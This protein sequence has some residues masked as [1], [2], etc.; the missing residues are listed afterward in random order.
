MGDTQQ[1]LAWTHWALLIGAD[2]AINSTNTPNSSEAP[3][4]RGRSLKGAVADITAVNDYLTF[5][6]PSGIKVT[7]LTFMKS[8]GEESAEERSENTDGLP[9]IDNVRSALQEITDQCPRGG[10]KE[11]YIH[12]SGHGTRVGGNGPLALVLY[13]PRGRGVSYLRSMELARA[14][15]KMVKLGMR[16]TLVLDCCFSASTHRAGNFQ[17]NKIRFIEYDA[18]ADAESDPAV[19]SFIEEDAHA[20]GVRTSTFQPDRLLDPT[21]YTVI[22]ACGPNENAWEI[23]LSDGVRRGALSYF[24]DRTLKTLRKAGT[25]ISFVTLYHH[26]QARFHAK[27]QQQMPRWYGNTETCFFQDIQ[28]SKD[29]GLEFVFGFYD[30]ENEEFVLNAGEA[31]GVH[32]KDEYEAH[33]YHASEDRVT[34]SNEGLVK[35]RVEE[36]RGLTSRVTVIDPSYIHKLKKSPTWKAKPTISFN[37]RKVPVHLLPSLSDPDRLQLIQSLEGNG[38]LQISSEGNLSESSAFMVGVDSSNAYDIR[39]GG[40]RAILNLPMIT[41]DSGD[42]L[43]LLGTVLTHLT[44]FKFFEGMENREP[45]REFESTFSLDFSHEL[46]GDGFFE[47]KHETS[48]TLTF[49]N[50]GDVPIYIAVFN[51]RP[52]WEICNM[53]AE[54]GEGEHLEISGKDFPESNLE[55]PLTMEVPERFREI[56]QRQATDII[57]L[58]I[59]SKAT[60]FP[61][62]LL[63]KMKGLEVASNT[64][65]SSAEVLKFLDC[66]EEEF[67]RA[68]DGYEGKWTTRNFLIRTIM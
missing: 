19:N 31:H 42:G 56:G 22:A 4:L 66:F 44:A 24:L 15:D 67:C 51:F 8:G 16:V 32:E 54:A 12:F 41:R 40:S 35:L 53:I 39:D 27:F 17:R 6:S 34:E 59:T 50:L 36:A 3:R 49:K 48:W 7:K 30:E 23:E 64:R 10:N 33:P 45:N 38:F 55:L 14:I 11:V 47:V 63:P 1:E 58:F 46:G 52:S 18:V 13:H 57:K 37:P 20:H 62:M 28:G 21:G 5:G 9:T 26:L 61:K 25:K 65:D 29:I 68:G 43:S 2:T 60:S